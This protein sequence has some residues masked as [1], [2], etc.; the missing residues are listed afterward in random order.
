MLLYD[1]K[2]RI[3]LF[4][5]IESSPCALLFPMYFLISTQKTEAYLQILQFRLLTS[6]RYSHF[7]LWKIFNR[8]KWSLCTCYFSLWKERFACLFV[9]ALFFS[10]AEPLLSIWTRQIGFSLDIQF[11][12]SFSQQIQLTQL[13]HICIT[14]LLHISYYILWCY[15]LSYKLLQII[16]YLRL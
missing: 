13:L 8:L 2:L 15:I 6:K 11:I 5:M 10:L 7:L 12:Y 4:D 3:T 9:F 14:K 1:M 16:T